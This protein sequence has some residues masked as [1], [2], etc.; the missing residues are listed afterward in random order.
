M[1]ITNSSIDSYPAASEHCL[2]FSSSSPS[3][4]TLCEPNMISPVF[5]RLLVERRASLPGKTGET[6]VAPPYVK[7]L[8]RLKHRLPHHILRLR[9]SE[10]RQNRGSDVGQRRSLRV[11]LAVAQQ[12]SR[13]LGEV[14]AMIAAPRIRVVLKHVRRKRPQNRLPSR[15][16]PAVIPDERI[17]TR[18]RIWPLVG[19]GCQIDSRNHLRTIL[20]IAN[21]QKLLPDFP[22]QRIGLSA[23]LDNAL[24]LTSA[25]I[26]V[27]SVNPKPVSP[28]PAPVHIGEGLAR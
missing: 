14:H 12:H 27:K 5:K 10:F 20:R 9:D 26:Q 3:I 7:A 13:H 15:A 24:T 1:W 2:T 4:F 6:P 23:R 19:F 22:Q 28:R 17:R 16:I 25:D 21:L 11:N 8:A 18:A